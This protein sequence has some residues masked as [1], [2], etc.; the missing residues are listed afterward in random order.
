MDIVH[1]V[2]VIEIRTKLRHLLIDMD[3]VLEITR[4][5]HVA[6]ARMN[7]IKSIEKLSFVETTPINQ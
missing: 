6:D 2:K 3:S 4:D 5:M 7:L 1:H